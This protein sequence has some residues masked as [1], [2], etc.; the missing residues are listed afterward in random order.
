MNDECMFIYAF[1]V[2]D[3]WGPKMYYVA[4]HMMK[5]E[6]YVFWKVIG[7]TLL[8]Q[9]S[10][11]VRCCNGLRDCFSRSLAFRVPRIVYNSV[12]CPPFRRYILLTH[13]AC[14][15]FALGRI[16]CSPSAGL[17]YCFFSAQPVGDRWTSRVVANFGTVFNRAWRL[18]IR[19]D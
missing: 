5:V 4:H 12:G 16:C 15:N 9:A 8:S 1:I 7:P 14:V 17:V 19:S 10:C 13:M 18:D 2:E 11:G 3:W 6:H